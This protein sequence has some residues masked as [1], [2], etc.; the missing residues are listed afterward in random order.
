MITNETC[1]EKN[2]I[3]VIGR[4]PHGNRFHKATVYGMEC[5]QIEYTFKQKKYEG[6]VD[7]SLQCAWAGG[8]NHSRLDVVKRRNAILKNTFQ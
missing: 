8:I 5:G 2:K 4:L 6:N 1:L 3:V 7:G